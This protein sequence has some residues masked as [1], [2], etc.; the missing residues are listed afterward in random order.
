VRRRLL[1]ALVLAGAALVALLALDRSP[2]PSLLVLTIDTMRADAVGEGT[3]AILD[4]LRS[5]TRFRGARTVAPLTLPA[6]VSLFT[7]LLPAH[8]RVHDNVTEPIPSPEARGF[9]LLAE[10]LRGKGYAT[11]AFVAESVL[12]PETGLAQGFDSYQCRQH[13]RAGGYTPAPEQADAAIAWLAQRD[14]D[15][16]F[17]LWVHLFDPHTPYFPF[18][19]DGRRKGTLAED[20]PEVRYAGEVRRADAAIE[21]ILAAV[22]P[23]VVV[24]VASD[25][26]EALGEH[27]ESTHGAL[28][29]GATVDAFLAVRGEGF[30]AGAEGAGPRSLCDVAPTLRVLCGLPARPS[31]GAPLGGPAHEVVVSESI[32]AWR[33]HGW[34]QCFAASDGAFTLVESGPRREL[35]D[36]AADP[37][38][39]RPVDPEGHP[40]QARLERALLALRSTDPGDAR[41]SQLYP[42]VSPYAGARRP[43]V[44]Y[45]PAPENAQL[46]DAR[47]LLRVW[48]QLET[49]PEAILRAGARKDV[50]TLRA[51]AEELRLLA[52]E[53]RVS[54]VPHQ[55]RA[56]A[57][58]ELARL[59]GERDGF[60][61]AAHELALSIELGHVLP[62][63]FAEAA[64]CA[65]LGRA[66]EEMR[67]I[68]ELAAKKRLEP[69]EAT[70]RALTVAAHA[71]DLAAELDASGLG[72]R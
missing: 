42:S 25:H 72:K 29:Y 17:L 22:G 32:Y 8:H 3:P 11:A 51:V 5:A 53:A 36:R 55:Y 46:P 41:E 43:L 60:R 27:D 62:Q 49:I 23:D 19:G 65:Q 28:C 63:T 70:A 24:V 12:A 18:P 6:H 21:R 34:G 69:D 50:Q 64:R 16:P 68:L 45:V 58:S 61:E 9:T 10:E 13:A 35:F 2:R 39:A 57:L 44:S 26:G 4:F 54:P 38:E 33:V 59:T 20:L 31:D 14:P 40:A 15:R 30:A 71:L 47:P 1:P 37:K 52:G 66:P 56:H 67:R 48:E 7:G